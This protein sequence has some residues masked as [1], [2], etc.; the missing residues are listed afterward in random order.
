MSKNYIGVPLSSLSSLSSLTSLSALVLA[1]IACPAQAAAPLKIALVETLSG[2]QAST[3][4]LYRAAVK[5]EMD[6]INAA[7]GWNGQAV[8]LAEYDNQGGPA[9]ASDKV[10]AAIAAGAQIIIQGSSSAV[11]GQITEDV[12]KH[13]LR[14]AGKEVLF[15]NMGGEALELTGDK[16]HFYH[17]R[18]TTNAV[19]RVKT[20]VPAM[21]EAKEL[22]SKVY[23]MNQNYSWGMDMDKAIKDD[24]AAGGYTVVESTL[25]DVN[26][27]QDFSPYVAKIKASGA[28]T[29]LT[30]NWSN[31]LLL[32][33][34]ATRAAGLKVRFG[35]VFLDQP[36]NI[37]NAGDTALGHF[38]S[39]A[40]NIETNKATEEFA[41]D[42]KAKTGHFPTFIEP[43][44]VF[45]MQ[46]LGEALK[47]VKPSGDKINV[48]ELAKA[49]EKVR[50]ETPMGETS[51]RAADHQVVLPIVVSR[52]EKNVK[53]KVDD[54]DMG[55]KVIKKFSGEDAV[56]PVQTSCKM[57]RPS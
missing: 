54:T 12:R 18:F 55:F 48:T 20:L 27:I 40:F 13:N 21:K 41:T 32:L 5:Y 3:G 9:G 10:K 49:L 2:P 31:D 4:L 44:T 39:H 38:I 52:V 37:G 53:Y 57:Q 30:G 22:G 14:N 7:G 34:K 11:S 25:H 6:R 50:I 24:A 35:T 16:C 42:Y 19:I 33:M 45:G 56:N 46:M 26:K 23:A 1:A 43:Q 8:Q 36:G 15:M 29:V 17:F 51:I 28:D 47:Q